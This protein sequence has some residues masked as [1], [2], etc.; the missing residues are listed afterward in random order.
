VSVGDGVSVLAGVLIGVLAIANK[1]K[2][3][4]RRLDVLGILSSY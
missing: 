2:R 3:P 4:I 1:A